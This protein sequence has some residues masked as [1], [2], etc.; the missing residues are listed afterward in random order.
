LFKRGLIHRRANFQQSAEEELNNA[1][2]AGQLPGLAQ[3]QD[4]FMI[5]ADMEARRFEEENQFVP[6]ENGNMV[7]ATAGGEGSLGFSQAGAEAGAAAAAAE[8]IGTDTLGV[9]A[10]AAFAGPEGE[11]RLLRDI[12]RDSTERWQLPTLGAD[13]E[14]A[15]Q[16][17]AMGYST[18]EVAEKMTERARDYQRML[19]AG[20]KRYPQ[21][22]PVKIP[23]LD[24]VCIRSVAAGYAH[25]LLLSEDGRLFGAGYNDRG[26]LGLGYVR[27]T[28]IMLCF[29]L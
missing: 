17:H 28:V 12:V 2:Q 27:V 19:L 13:R 11:S 15:I 6:D 18:E 16:M 25:V 1:T 24:H 22:R 7:L 23:N 9:A 20:C 8:M 3:D 4:T 14:Y 10:T 21:P 29:L 5:A 26:Q